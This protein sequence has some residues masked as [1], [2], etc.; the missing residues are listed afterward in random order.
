MNPREYWYNKAKHLHDFMCKYPNITLGDALALSAHNL[1]M[2]AALGD[3]I[4]LLRM[5]SFLAKEIETNSEYYNIPL[6]PYGVQHQHNSDSS[7]SQTSRDTTNDERVDSG[8]QIKKTTISS[9]QAS[10]SNY[11]EQPNR[12]RIQRPKEDVQSK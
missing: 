10:P 5:A 9:V 11:F 3:N 8:I 7:S 4:S 1:F 12:E 6:K 2:L